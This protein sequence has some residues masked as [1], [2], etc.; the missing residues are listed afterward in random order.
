V[1]RSVNTAP[2]QYG[3]IGHPV[4]HSWSPFIHGLFARQTEQQMVY[5][6]FDVPPAK[7]RRHVMHFF[8][9]GGRGLNVTLPHKIEAAGIA[10]ELTPRAERA[11]AVN[12]LM[13][14]GENELIGDNT[15]G[16]GLVRDLEDTCGV[17][18]KGTR[19][20]ILGAGGAARGVLAPLLALGPSEIVIANR[21]EAR[22]C[23]LAREF[24]QLGNLFG[25]AF[26]SDLLTDFDLIINATSASTDGDSPVIA[27]TLVSPRTTC[28]DMAYSKEKTPFVRWAESHGCAR[29]LQGWGMLVEQAAESFSVW[30]GIRPQ[31]A[32]VL[33]ALIAS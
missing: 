1:G 12:T 21:T 15:D 7:F 4:A 24:A 14:Q 8:L 33:Q 27:S 32:P 31:T 22:A 20:L 5:R 16:E 9:H 3:V 13:M 25:C 2:D 6:R 29:A 30:R 17:T 10:S 28:Y 26:D 18:L 23:T 11:G 19:I